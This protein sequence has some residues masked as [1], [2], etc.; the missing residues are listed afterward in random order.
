MNLGILLWNTCNAVCS[1]CAVSSAPREVG[2]MEDDQIIGLIDSAFYDDPQPRIGLS[3]GEAF[4]YFERLCKFIMHATGRGARVSVNTNAFW[5]VTLERAREKVQLLKELRLS[6][7]VVSFDDFHEAFINR[8]RVLNV[9]RACKE[10][11]LEVKL[12]YVATTSTNRLSDFLRDCGDDLLNIECREIP[13]HPVGR[14]A[15]M[16]PEAEILISPGVPVGLCPSSIL[17]ISAYGKVIP[18]CN[19]AGHLPA[20]EVGT[21]EQPIVE[22][23]HKFLNDP[24]LA[25]LRREGPKAL[26]ETAVQA[27]YELKDGYVDQCHLC[28]DL[29]KS[30]S[31]ATALTTAARELRDESI[32]G[33]YVS[34]FNENMES[35]RTSG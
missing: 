5:G 6:Q 16:I 26:V 12:Q 32:L 24:T 21:I 3:G 17:S 9:I 30:E 7:L 11:Q 19:A 22:L 33:D 28:Y 10:L 13:C 14:A 4:V 31:V 2:Y 15:A 18:C 25:L 23:H 20:L 27:G 29:F 8:E 1:H 35:A 34:Q